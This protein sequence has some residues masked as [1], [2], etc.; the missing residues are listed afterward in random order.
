MFKQLCHLILCK[1]FSNFFFLPLFVIFFFLRICFETGQ[2]RLFICIGNGWLH[3]IIIPSHLPMNFW[4][5]FFLSRSLSFVRL[6]CFVELPSSSSSSSTSSSLSF[7]SFSFKYHEN[8]A[9]YRMAN[10]CW[11]HRMLSLSL[12]PPLSFFLH[13]MVEPQKCR[14]A[15]VVLGLMHLLSQNFHDENCTRNVKRM[16]MA[17]WVVQVSAYEHH[18]ELNNFECGI[19][20][21]DKSDLVVTW[22]WKYNYG[23]FTFVCIANFMYPFPLVC[24]PASQP[25]SKFSVKYPVCEQVNERRNEPM[26]FWQNHESFNYLFSRNLRLKDQRR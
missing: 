12:S 5:F 7:S 21:L 8:N 23:L 13:C 16:A 25:Q 26:A 1:I 14:I 20:W 19:Q 24:L 22:N 15:I 11:C 10:K 6:S 9:W 17:V 2:I 18:I 4:V 3:W